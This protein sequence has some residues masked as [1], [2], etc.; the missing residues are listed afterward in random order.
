[1]ERVSQGLILFFVRNRD[2]EGLQP[3]R[4]GAGLAQKHN[5]GG[6]GT[7][8][9]LIYMDMESGFYKYRMPCK[10]MG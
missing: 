9:T 1:M 2:P 4:A 7:Q 10:P 6:K 8:M 3:C 5:T